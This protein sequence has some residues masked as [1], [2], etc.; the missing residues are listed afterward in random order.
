MKRILCLFLM[1]FSISYAQEL[2]TKK[3][4]LVG[5]PIRQKPNILKEFLQSL[6]EL[7][8]QTCII[9][10][11]FVDDNTQEESR[12]QLQSFAQDISAQVF[13]TK[14]DQVNDVYVCNELTHYWSDAIIWK[15]A[16]FK[17]VIFEFALAHN[18]DY[19]FLI[20]S[21]IVLHPQT[22]DQLIA[23][24][25]E[26][27]SEIFWTHWQPGFRKSP[28]VWLYDTYTQYEVGCGENLT[29]EDVHLRHNEF[30]STMLNPGLYPVGGLGACTLISKKALDRG[31]RFKKIN[32]LTFWGEDRHFC[33]RAA[34]LDIGMWVDT[35]YPAYHIYRESDLAGVA[36]YKENCRN[37]I[38][39]V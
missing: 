5:S 9:D 39:Q 12:Q 4:V 18:Y 21:D 38:Y 24:N 35:Y 26:I 15:V 22:I 29:N 25:K 37:G 13:I 7:D 32:N 14:A 2:P 3:R 20:D 27:V 33:I 19:V 11:C 31:A 10:F 30:I 23:D 34:A 6:K 28:Q 17:D 36:Q 16:H 8:Q 1:S